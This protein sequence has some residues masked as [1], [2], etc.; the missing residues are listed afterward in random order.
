MSKKHVVNFGC[1]YPLTTIRHIL[2]FCIPNN[3]STVADVSFRF[4]KYVLS[5][6]GELHLQTCITITFPYEI[7]CV[8]KALVETARGY[9]TTT[10]QMTL[11][12]PSILHSML[13]AAEKLQSTSYDPVLTSL[14][15]YMYSVHKATNL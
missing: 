2:A 12:L 7:L 9:N 14:S 11:L 4:Q 10:H 8:L 5:P 6:T 3:F 13:K 1:S 15:R